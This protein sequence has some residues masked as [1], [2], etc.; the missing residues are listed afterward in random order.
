MGIFFFRGGGSWTPSE[1]I[2][3]L[4]QE[5]QIVPEMMTADVRDPP[6]TN[7]AIFEM[8]WSAKSNIYTLDYEEFISTGA[9][10][11]KP[12]KKE[13]IKLDKI[14]RVHKKKAIKLAKMVDHHLSVDTE[15]I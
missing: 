6:K 3:L 10:R 14:K 7:Q 4:T 1:V 8:T 13:N 5:I 9:G 11:Y 12:A 2:Y 15:K